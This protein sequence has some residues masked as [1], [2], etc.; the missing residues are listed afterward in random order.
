MDNGIPIDGAQTTSDQF[1][2]MQRELDAAVAWGKGLKE[3]DIMPNDD[4]QR[5]KVLVA[6]FEGCQD[7][8]NTMLENTKKRF[9][10]A[11][12][13]AAQELF[14]KQAGGGKG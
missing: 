4:V 7:A 3:G 12:R 6:A 10:D 1:K 5:V 9:E 14:E 2:E 11:V 8:M 13:V